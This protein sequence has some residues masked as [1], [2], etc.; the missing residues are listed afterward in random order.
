MEVDELRKDFPVLSREVDGKEIAY[1]DNA[2]MTLKPIQVISKIKKYYAEQGA[3]AGKR[4]SHRLSR[5]TQ[6]KAMEAR[7]KV[8]DFIN[9]DK[10]E[11]VWTRNTT[12]AVNLVANSIDL[13]EGE[14]IVASN[15]D[16]H[17]GILPFWRIC[18][19][20][21]ADLRVV[22]AGKKGFFS[23]DQWREKIDSDT[24]LVSLIHVSNVTG[25]EAPVENIVEIAH[26]NGAKVLLDGAQSVPHQEV[27]VKSLDIDFM[28]F[29]IHKM[30]G[31][32]GMGVLYG[33][34][35]HLEYMDRFMVG[36]D[37][38]RDVEYVDGSLEPEFLSAPQ[39]FEAGLQNYAGIIG[40]GAAI[41]YLQGIGMENI[42]RLEEKL[43]EKLHRKIRDLEGVKIVGPENHEMRKSLVS[44]HLDSEKV[45]E[46]DLAEFL[47]K[48]KNVYL[49]AGH[50]CTAPFHHYTGLDPKKGRGSL[51][52]SLYFYNRMEDI[53]RLEEGIEEFLKK[54]NL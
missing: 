30:L 32:T 39:K 2:C 19:Q 28:A 14:N 48:E 51:R 23:E 15:L 3:C 5:E 33:K 36:G 22:G 27:D 7:A 29:S 40:T 54:L 16:H 41:D 26:E 52:A 24:E 31:P 38:V 45:S 1:L 18:N 8:A 47:N 10:D 25:T 9:A 37:T 50:H 53:E 43:L 34:G 6:R 49:R 20:K 12:E 4:S 44:F 11:I 13:E 46:K 35:R 21:N 17:S 42:E